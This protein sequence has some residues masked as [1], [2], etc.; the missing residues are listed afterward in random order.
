MPKKH[1]SFSQISKY[2]KCGE[3]YRR[4][5]IEHERLPPNVSMIV[6]SAIHYSQEVSE[7]HAI[8]GGRVDTETAVILALQY[9]HENKGEIGWSQNDIDDYL[10]R[11]EK[12]CHKRVKAFESE[13]K[14]TLKLM[15]ADY[16]RE[17]KKEKK[18]VNEL[19]LKEKLKKKIESFNQFMKKETDEHSLYVDSLDEESIVE[20]LEKEAEDKVSRLTYTYHE[21]Y[22]K[23]SKPF[24]VEMPF[25]LNI[26]GIYTPIVGFMDLIEGPFRMHDDKEAYIIIDTKT[27]TKSPPEDDI[28][29]DLQLSIYDM[30]FRQ[31]FNKKPYRLKK[32]WVV[33]TTEVKVIEQ[34]AEARSPE[35]LDRVINRIKVTEQCIQ[36]QM[37]LPAPQG[38]WWCSKK[39]CNYWDDCKLRS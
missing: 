13:H 22:G 14:K 30:A 38:C 12:Q 20:L 28:D 29:E 3:Q 19:D 9:W 18:E 15:E 27:A 33:D 32:R 36:K 17:A 10:E 39:W 34:V 4:A 23:T 2:L 6:G 7:K 8:D 5:Y 16:K 37:F 35:Q 11:L 25:T 24:E 31:I 26:E 1:L 21:A